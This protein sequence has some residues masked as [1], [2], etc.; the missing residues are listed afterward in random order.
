VYVVTFQ[1]GVLAQQIIDGVAGSEHAQHVFNGQSPA[2]DDWLAAEDLRIDR[3]SRQ[4]RVLDISH[5]KTSPKKHSKQT[6][7]AAGS[8]VLVQVHCSPLILPLTGV[9]AK[10]T[11]VSVHIDILVDDGSG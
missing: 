6:L 9:M 4:K 1:P 5:L 10:P 11:A 3:D 2:S 7:P 8:L